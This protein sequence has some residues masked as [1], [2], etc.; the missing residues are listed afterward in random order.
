[1]LRLIS[2]LL[3]LPIAQTSLAEVSEEVK[4]KIE[5]IQ[6]GVIEV[7]FSR[8]QASVHRRN[9]QPPGKTTHEQVAGRQPGRVLTATQRDAANRAEPKRR[10]PHHP[11]RQQKPLPSDQQIQR[12]R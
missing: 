11:P 12:C 9:D 10:G 6:A 4:A 5:G 2:V 8:G 7:Q 3:M 1:M